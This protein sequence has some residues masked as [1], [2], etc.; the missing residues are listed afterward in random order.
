[1]PASATVGGAPVPVEVEH[2]ERVVRVVVRGVPS[3][4]QLAV[5]LGAGS[6]IGLAHDDTDARLFAV[7]D[8][9]RVEY[10]LKAEAYRV[11]TSSLPLHVRLS[12][13]RA[14]DLPSALAAAVEEVLVARA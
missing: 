14:L 13:L 8:R 9:A 5:A 3:G 2:D 11:A 10:D 7:L 12:H 4:S 1:M 6:R